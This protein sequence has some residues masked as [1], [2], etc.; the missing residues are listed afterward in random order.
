MKIFSFLQKLSL[1]ERKLTWLALG[2][3]GVSFFYGLVLSPLMHSQSN[4]KASFKKANQQQV[5][6]KEQVAG[7][8]ASGKDK[9]LNRNEL[10]KLLDSMNMNRFVTKTQPKGERVR[11]TLDRVP[12]AKMWAWLVE[13]E[14]QGGVIEDLSLERA[15]KGETVRVVVLIG[16]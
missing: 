1:R 11:L 14:E 5:W 13:V 3:L 7:I 9:S 10:D 2:L 12:P 6:L 16:F 8:T 15:V 4:A